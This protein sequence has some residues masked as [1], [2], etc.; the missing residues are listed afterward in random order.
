VV[1]FWKLLLLVLVIGGVWAGITIY[2]R[3]QRQRELA[4]AQARRTQPNLGHI[5]TVACRICG[6][7]VPERGTKRCERADCPF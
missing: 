4:E 6:T 7:Y 3:S 1:S 5:K 2:K